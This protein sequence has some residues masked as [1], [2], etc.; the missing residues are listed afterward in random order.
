MLFLVTVLITSALSQKS[1]MYVLHLPT[2]SYANKA[3]VIGRICSTNGENINVCHFRLN[4]LHGRDSI[5][6]SSEWSVPPWSLGRGG[7]ANQ[8]SASSLD[9]RRKNW[10]WKDDTK[11]IQNINT[12]LYIS[13]PLM[14]Y[15]NGVEVVIFLWIYTQ[16]VG[17][18]GR[19]IGLS[20]GHYLNTGQ[21]KHRKTRTHIHTHAP[22]IHA[23]SGIRAHDH[24]VRASEESSCL[25]PLGNRD[26]QKY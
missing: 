10:N 25:W 2:L 8:T 7:D 23:L 22:N 20:Q 18:L 4:N 26:W 24:S 5:G 9:F 1:V 21:H 14:P 15:S 6:M 3:I 17:F 11:N 19:V 13:I 16:S 12:F